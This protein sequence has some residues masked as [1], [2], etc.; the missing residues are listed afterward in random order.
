MAVT[1]ATAHKAVKRWHLDG[2]RVIP[3]V[4]A[5]SCRFW[6]MG[7]GGGYRRVYACPA[8]RQAW[9]D[10]HPGFVFGTHAHA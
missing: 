1:E 10:T 5:C 8:H 9:E 4:G 3:G 2:G 7:P 6:M